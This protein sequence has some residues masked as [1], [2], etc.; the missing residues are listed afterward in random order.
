MRSLKFLPVLFAKE[1]RELL[2]SRA[3]WIL[4]IF[5]GPLVGNSFITAVNFYAEA[6]G[7]GTG[8]AAGPLG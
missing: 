6:S 5:I 7:A 4:L 2:A 3:S 1:W 8:E